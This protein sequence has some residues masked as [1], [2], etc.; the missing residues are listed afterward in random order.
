MT[1]IEQI[2]QSMTDRGI[3]RDV[4]ARVLRLNADVP[5]GQRLRGWHPSPTARRSIHLDVVT[6]E[7]FEQKWGAHAARGLQ[8]GDFI[9]GGGKRRWITGFAYRRGPHDP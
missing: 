2:A 5:A 8:P 7:D 4:V 3:G 6:R 1:P 9:S